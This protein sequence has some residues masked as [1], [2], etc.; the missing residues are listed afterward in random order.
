MS[1]EQSILSRGIIQN[2]FFSK[3]MPLFQLRLFILYQA[4]HSSGLALVCS[5]V[6]T[7]TVPSASHKDFCKHYYFCLFIVATGCPSERRP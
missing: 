7:L 2:D 3:I 1:K 5:T 4:Y 6:V